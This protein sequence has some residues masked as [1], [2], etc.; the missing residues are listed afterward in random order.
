MFINTKRK[1]TARDIAYEFKV[2]VRTAHRYLL[3][4]SEMGV[5]LYTEPGRNGGYRLLDNRTLPPIIFNE[6]E[7]IAIFFA[8][9]AL[10]YF[11]T[12]PFTIDL[13]SVSRKL[14]A[15]L[16][17]DTRD[18]IDH[19]ESVLSFWNKKRGISAPFLKEII[20]AALE[21]QVLMI[22][23]QSRYKNTNREI[24]PLGVY[25]YDGF[26]YMPAFDLSHNEIRVFRLDRILTLKHTQK[27]HTPKINLES[28]LERLSAQDPKDPVRLYVELTKEGI[29]QT[30]R[31]F[32]HAFPQG[33]VLFKKIDNSREQTRPGG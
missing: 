22:E 31:H 15:S 18:K 33:C 23:Y 2:S 27:K 21:N 1:F 10:K 17:A 25:A 12:L 4:L 20:A 30:A 8:F 11:K 28:W 6:N 14:S 3:E 32:E 5:P 13:Q 29:R 19:L 24:T 7:A 16:P 26:W 9:Q